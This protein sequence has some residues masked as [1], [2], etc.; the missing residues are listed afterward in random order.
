MLFLFLLL[1]L[2]STSSNSSLKYSPSYSNTLLDSGIEF[3]LHDT[4]PNKKGMK[5]LEQIL[6]ELSFYYTRGDFVLRLTPD[7]DLREFKR[8]S[9]IGIKRCKF[10]EKSAKRYFSKT[11]VL[12]EDPSYEKI[13]EFKLYVLPYNPRVFCDVIKE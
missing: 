7:N 12:I 13:E 6:P 2:S 9:L 11:K 5:R 8:D 3:D 4:I 1:L 10:I